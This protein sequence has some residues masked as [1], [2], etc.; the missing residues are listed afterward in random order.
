MNKYEFDKFDEDI[1]SLIKDI[2]NKIKELAIKHF[3][4]GQDEFI[5]QILGFDAVDLI[6]WAIDQK[7]SK[8]KPYLLL[9]SILRLEN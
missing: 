5:D 6:K 8:G 4:H 2:D 9:K 3:N 7:K 1:D